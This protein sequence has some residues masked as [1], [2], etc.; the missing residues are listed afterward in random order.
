MRVATH[1]MSH[2]A[3]EAANRKSAATY[4]PTP[5][6]GDPNYGAFRK[7]WMDAYIEAGGGYEEVQ[8]EKHRKHVQ[9]ARKKAAKHAGFRGAVAPCVPAGRSTHQPQGHA[10]QAKPHA[11]VKPVKEA[12]PPADCACKLVALN[13]TC[14]HGRSAKDQLLMVVSEHA[15]GDEIVVK[16]TGQGDCATRLMVR[17]DGKN[18]YP[19]EGPRESRFRA[20]QPTPGLTLPWKVPP[21]TTMVTAESDGCTR[22][23]KVLSFP[24]KKRSLNIDVDKLRKAF[25]KI[26]SVLPVDKGG[27]KPAES[28]EKEG[29]KKKSNFEKMEK[30]EEIVAAAQWQEEAGS[31]LAYCHM[32][33]EAKIAPIFGFEGKVP[34]YAL[35]MPPALTEFAAA[36]VYLSL[37]A[38]VS[39]SAECDW[40]YW[41]HEDSC[42]WK[43]LEVKLDG[44]ASAELAAELMVHKALQ[45]KAW[46]KTAA[47]ISGWA[48]KE[49]EET[50]VLGW[51][52]SWDPL[53]AGV[54][55]K[56]PWGLPKWTPKWTVLEKMQT[57]KHTMPLVYEG[58]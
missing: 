26:V 24:A 31:H 12:P 4:Q 5:Q 21:L 13:L 38:S 22:T 29:D 49:S 11:H 46:G 53:T 48:E 56:P 3:V 17:A 50:P 6:P 27:D 35:P 41:P 19:C 25:D 2:S 20:E 39:V 23:V 51:E 52:G 16:P 40:S 58:A 55:V 54:V 34:L 45:V 42:K 36:G 32:S 28:T 10:H 33:L 37:E 18:G 47:A 44:D 1:P 8:G 15:Q 9:Q 57:G 14:G 7:Q 30:K 43:K